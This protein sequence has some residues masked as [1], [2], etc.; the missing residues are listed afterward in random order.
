ME[1]KNKGGRPMKYTPEQLKKLFDE[2]VKKEAD[3]PIEKKVE[4]INKGKTS[5]KIEYFQRPLMQGNFFDYIDVSDRYFEDLMKYNSE[6]FS[7][8]VSYIKRKLNEQKLTGAIIGV[9][10][11]SIVAQHLG[12]TNKVDVT[13]KGDKITETD[14]ELKKDVKELLRKCDGLL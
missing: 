11:S 6:E 3:N 10:N 2:W 4:F 9:Y 7:H 14:E 12:M 8:V 5:K 1:K 13:T